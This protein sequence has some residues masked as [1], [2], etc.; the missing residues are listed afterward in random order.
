MAESEPLRGR[1]SAQQKFRF[2]EMPLPGFA[3][4]L[5][6]GVGNRGSNLGRLHIP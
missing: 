2:V 5:E 3:G 6:Q 4:G 1:K